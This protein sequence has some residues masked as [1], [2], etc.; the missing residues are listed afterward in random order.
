MKKLYLLLSVLL[1]FSVGMSQNKVN[2]NNLVQY[3]NK[4][5]KENEDIPFT[6]LVFDFSQETGIKIVEFKI[7]E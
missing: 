4:W 7:F 3:G 5:F 2:I 6:G 1:F